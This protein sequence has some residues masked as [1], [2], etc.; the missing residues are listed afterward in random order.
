M[1]CALFEEAVNASWGAS[2]GPYA[3]GGSTSDHE[4]IRPGMLPESWIDYSGVDL[5]AVPLA[6][7]DGLSAAE[8]SAIVMIPARDPAA[9]VRALALEGIIADA[10]P[11]HVRLSPFFYNVQE[12]HGRALERL[13]AM[14]M[15]AMMASELEFFL[16][17][18]SYDSAGV[19][20]YR[21]LKTA[22]NFIQDYHILQTTKEE[23]VMRAITS[24]K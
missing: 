5:V 18:E 17:D 21:G 6:T 22:G 12:D 9:A 2:S 3:Y 4:I 8:R 7:L 13:A 1:D 10:R 11:G 14:D 16:F 15:K 23:A 24:E 20:G 19:K